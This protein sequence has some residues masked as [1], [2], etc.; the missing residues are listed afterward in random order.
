MKIL[1]EARGARLTTASDFSLEIMQA[2][3][4][5]E[6]FCVERKKK[7]HLRILYPA[8]LSSVSAGEMKTFS[9]KQKM[10]EFVIR[11]LI[12]QEM[13]KECLQKERNDIGQKL[14]SIF[15]S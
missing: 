5:S 8:K 15:Y 4:K 10:M 6:I 1:K 7:K 11:R 12:L 9:D 2:R 13:Q 14:R 3:E